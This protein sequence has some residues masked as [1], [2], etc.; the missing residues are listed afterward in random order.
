MPNPLS[1][2]VP[3]HHRHRA[4]RGIPNRRVGLTVGSA[5]Q[6]PMTSPRDAEPLLTL[7][8]AYLAAYCFIRQFY[9][10]DATTPASMFHLLAW[11]DL[12]GDR[13]THDPAQWHDWLQSVDR[14]LTDG[15]TVMSTDPLPQ[16]RS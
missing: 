1:G 10:R 9:E 6:C 13:Q 4:G 14:V 16:P 7:D 11:M 3:Y 8:Q 2:G 5:S 12:E 15:S